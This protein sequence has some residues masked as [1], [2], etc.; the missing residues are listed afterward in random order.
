MKKIEDHLDY[1]KIL[2]E[3]IA[4]LTLCDHM[5]DVSNEIV[6]VLKRIDFKY[7]SSNEDEFEYLQDALRK[8]GIKTL[9]GIELEGLEG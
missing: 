4:S 9:G 5:G 7:D 8:E 3:L 1:R 2:L 6:E